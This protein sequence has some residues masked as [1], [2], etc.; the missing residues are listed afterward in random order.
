LL[1][2]SEEQSDKLTKAVDE[3]L[4]SVDAASDKISRLTERQRSLQEIYD[5]LSLS[6]Y[7][8]KGLLSLPQGTNL[9]LLSPS[10]SQE[11]AYQ[12]I[13]AGDVS[14]QEW[15]ALKSRPEMREDIL[16]KNIAL[17]DIR[18]EVIKTFPGGA[19]IFLQP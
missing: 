19:F 15:Q 7:E 3:K 18:R 6:Q 12:P 4:L 11:K 13:L 1:N 2:E 9:A 8:L 14:A 17:D 10:V 5:R 16:Q